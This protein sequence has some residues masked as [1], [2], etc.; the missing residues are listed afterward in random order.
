M[1][2]VGKFFQKKM[3]ETYHMSLK[4]NFLNFTRNQNF[5]VNLCY[6]HTQPGH[7]PI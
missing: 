5:C 2:E 4:K 3:S 7:E 1:K 6:S